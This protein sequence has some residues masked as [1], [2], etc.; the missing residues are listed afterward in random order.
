MARCW[1]SSPSPT[2]PPSTQAQRVRDVLR[3]CVGAQAWRVAASGRR[4]ALR[5]R[6][7]FCAGRPTVSGFW[8]SIT[9]LGRHHNLGLGA[10]ASIGRSPEHSCQR[11]PYHLA[12]ARHVSP[13]RRDIPTMFPG[14]WIRFPT[15]PRSI[16]EESSRRGVLRT[17]CLP[18]SNCP[19]TRRVS[20][21]IPGVN[22]SK[23]EP[24][25]NCD[26]PAGGGGTGRLF[27]LGGFVCGKLAPVGAAGG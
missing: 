25:L 3:R 7:T 15:K 6:I 5:R 23:V 14:R 9:S 24:P 18:P 20:Y 17:P 11:N 4:Q 10:A 26:W 22:E 21:Q 13:L 16:I 19:S 12:R 1:R 2:I 8:S 27:R